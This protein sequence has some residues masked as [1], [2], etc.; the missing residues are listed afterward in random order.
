M[1]VILPLCRRRTK[2][3]E[4]VLVVQAVLAGMRVGRVQA[5]TQRQMTVLEAAVAAAAVP[6]R[7]LAN[8]AG[9]DP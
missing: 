3:L 4:L 8:A 2:A 1:V 6:A 9:R 7:N 5:G